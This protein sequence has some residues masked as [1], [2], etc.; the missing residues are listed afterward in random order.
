MQVM[1]SIAADSNKNANINNV[2]TQRWTSKRSYRETGS[3]RRRRSC[4][5]VSTAVIIVDDA[6]LPQRLNGHHH[7]AWLPSSTKHI[8]LNSV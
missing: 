1:Q 4:V 3:I 7:A 8:T 5:Y 2:K 6:R